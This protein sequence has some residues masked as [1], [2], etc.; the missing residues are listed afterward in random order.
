MPR[1][2]FHPSSV[3]SPE[4]PVSSFCSCPLHVLFLMSIRGSW[5]GR[6]IGFRL[7][8]LPSV[9]LSPS[10][11][12]PISGRACLGQGEKQN[13][14]ESPLSS[15]VPCCEARLPHRPS[16]SAQHL[17]SPF[18]L[19]QQLLSLSN[20]RDPDPPAL[21]WEEWPLLWPLP[22]GLAPSLSSA[23]EF[24]PVQKTEGTGWG[25]GVRLSPG[26]WW[27]LVRERGWAGSNVKGLPDRESQRPTAGCPQRDGGF[28]PQLC[29]LRALKD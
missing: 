24:T 27:L 16:V 2:L 5:S 26:Q 21:P 6:N 20:S 10:G 12:I 13:Q 3:P 23:G 29:L 14:R 22:T 25:R 4:L 11:G 9:S 15:R 1:S 8:P 18:A 19:G 7:F 17:L 28:H